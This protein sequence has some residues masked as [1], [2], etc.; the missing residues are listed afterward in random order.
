MKKLLYIGFLLISVILGS[1]TEKEQYNIFNRVIGYM[2][3][4]PDSALLLL[5]QIPH[6][7]NLRGKQR[8]DYALLLTQ[9]RDKNY[10]DSLQSD[11]LIKFA[12]DYYQDSDNKEKAGKAFF[13]YGKV[14]ALQDKD[15]LAT[16]AYLDAQRWFER[17]NEYKMM[18][19]VQESIGRMNINRRMYE[20]AL[21]NYQQ[22]LNYYK[23]V[24]DTLGI[25]YIYRDIAR[26][27]SIRE[28]Y[29]KVIEYVNCGLT[30]YDQCNKSNA[31][32]K[33]ILPSYYQILGVTARDKG[34][35]TLAIKYLNIAILHEKNIHS[36]YHCL[37]SLGDVY[38]RMNRLEEAEN[39]F[40]QASK[41]ER[42]HTR[43][44]A[45]HYL[46]IL[47]KQ[48]K[49]FSQA[50]FYKEKSDTLLSITQDNYL[51]SQ[52]MSLQHKYDNERIILEKRRLEQEKKA[53]LY[54]G[55][56]VIL[57]IL[58]IGVGIYKYM[59]NRYEERIYR[60]LRVIMDNEK[61]IRQYSSEL[62]LLKQKEGEMVEK[63]KQEI[64][65]LNQKIL[66]LENENRTIRGNICVNGVYLLDQLKRK[67]LIVKNMTRQE[68]VQVLEYIDLINGSFI[69]RLKKEFLLTESNL[70]LAGLIKLGFT[71]TELTFTFD[72][73]VNSLYKK[74]NRLKEILHLDMDKKLDEFI[75][76]Y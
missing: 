50:L 15:T 65:K 35:Y 34:N 11:S 2:E 6:P 3:I 62:E 36:R 54:L 10:L 30:L 32:F 57:L 64:G 33:N 26:T 70:M 21:S 58:I 31:E 42:A 24:K 17:T 8:A 68:K 49:N 47:E 22:A 75:A 40:I 9:A 18:A 45:Y 51:K 44:G 69:S 61:R 56:V 38:L 53:Q 1:C 55:I 63:N 72:C 28:D 73:E 74:K 37:L 25:L 41:S 7:E 29:D 13:Y 14:M 46:Y 71:T 52:I 19:L 16:Q 5:N 23:M 43:S 48:R 4:Y 66:L 76:I 20:M 12:V 59:K 39:C 27:Y 67:E 60:N